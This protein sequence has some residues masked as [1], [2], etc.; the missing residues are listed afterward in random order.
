L[1]LAQFAGTCFGLIT[2]LNSPGSLATINHKNM[3]LQVDE[4]Q[5]NEIET[6]LQNLLQDYVFAS[7]ET[8]EGGGKRQGFVP[9]LV[10][11]NEDPLDD[12]LSLFSE[13]SIS[14]IYIP[15]YMISEYE[16]PELPL[17]TDS[18]PT[19]THHEQTPRLNRYLPAIP[20]SEDILEIPVANLRKQ[21]LPNSIERSKL[22]PETD[23]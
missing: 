8:E 12:T 11:P 22:V 13:V 15:E 17:R 1:E 2:F 18:R 23:N 20:L 4:F 16:I 21:S 5:T 3:F 7:D 9:P 19:L 6:I 10:P 14:S